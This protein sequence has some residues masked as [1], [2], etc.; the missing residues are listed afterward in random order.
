MFRAFYHGFSSFFPKLQPV[1]ASKELI[2]CA[3]QYMPSI[4]DGEGMTSITIKGLIYSRHDLST[5]TI[6]YE[7]GIYH[8]IETA[9]SRIYCDL[10]VVQ[11]L[12]FCRQEEGLSQAGLQWSEE[13]II[14]LIEGLGNRF[15]GTTSPCYT[16]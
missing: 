6:L 11:N 7:H 13:A 3:F 8:G 15:G 10:K 5:E 12:L 4:S 16:H 14:C 9:L 2:S 1:L